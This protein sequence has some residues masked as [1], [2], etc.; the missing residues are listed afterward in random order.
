[1]KFASL[2]L[3]LLCCAGL[4]SSA[5][6]SD[7]KQTQDYTNLL[8]IKA[9]YKEKDSIADKLK[10]EGIELQ[11]R[12]IYSAYLQLDKNASAIY[13]EGWWGWPNRKGKP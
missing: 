2:I 8:T 10:T 6:T 12:A 13:W 4:K 3:G 1:M 7:P 5:Q 11:K 9:V